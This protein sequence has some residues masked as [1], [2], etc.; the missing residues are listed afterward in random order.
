ME[1]IIREAVL[2]DADALQ[3]L[4]KYELGYDYP[5]KKTRAIM[6]KLTAGEHDKIFVAESDGIVIGYVHACTYEVLYG[7]PMKNI[8]GI[9]VDHHKRRQ[10]IATA[11][12]KAVEAWARACG[13]DGIR[14]VSGSQR[15]EAHACYRAYGFSSE[16][17]QINFKLM[18]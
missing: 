12:L 5:R 11:L 4:N 14:L 17:E 13:D 10:G 18:F 7:G 8:M 15:M 1:I 9:A 2:D 6:E 3:R 16:K